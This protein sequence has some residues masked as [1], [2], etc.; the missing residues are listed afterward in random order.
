MELT[1]TIDSI[2]KQLKELFGIDT[3]STMPIWRVVFSEDQFELRL[4]TYD[5]ITPAGLF[6][7]TVTEVRKVPKYKQWIHRKYLLERLVVV[8]THNKEELPDAKMSYEPIWVFEDKYGRYLPPRL[9]AAKFI[10][11]TIYAA[12]YS[13]HNL[14]R[15]KDPENSQEAVEELKKKRVDNLVEELFGDESSL[16]LTTMTGESIIVPQSYEKKGS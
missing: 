2:N 11:D 12:Q 4:G 15:Y 1:E 9:D 5:D 6:L 14:A 10:I 8:P 7:R 3:I 16:M 13:N